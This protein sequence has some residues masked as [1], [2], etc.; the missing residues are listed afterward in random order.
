MTKRSTKATELPL[1]AVP[2]FRSEEEER[3]FWATHDS[4]DYVDWKRARRVTFRIRPSTES[5]SP[6]SRRRCSAIWRCWRTDGR[7]VSVVA[8]GHLA[9]RVYQSCG[10]APEELAAMVREPGAHGKRRPGH[11]ARQ[12]LEGAPERPRRSKPNYSPA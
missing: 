5:I 6:A 12:E 8:E 11:R 2:R 3:Q 10:R 7:A 9:E 1:P 4:T